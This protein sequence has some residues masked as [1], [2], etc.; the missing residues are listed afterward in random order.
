MANK[1][2]N[3]SD[4]IKCYNCNSQMEKGVELIISKGR[5]IPQEIIKCNKCGKR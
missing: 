1:K 3:S 4:E 2:I 5:T